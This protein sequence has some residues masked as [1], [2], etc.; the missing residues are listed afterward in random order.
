MEEREEREVKI[1]MRWKGG[2]TERR[3]EVMYRPMVPVA[4]K[5]TMEVGV[6]DDIVLVR[7]GRWC[8][9]EDRWRDFRFEG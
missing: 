1:V 8:S 6:K 9:C 2:E 5:R 7:S 4:P 3:E